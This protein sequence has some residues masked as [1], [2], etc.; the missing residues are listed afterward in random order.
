MIKKLLFA[1]AMTCAYAM[2]QVQTTPAV[3]PHVTFLNNNGLA[4]AGCSLYTYQAGTTTPEPTYTD[5][6]GMSQNPNPIILG[7]DGGANIWLG[8]NSYKL[9]LKDTNGTTVFSVDNVNSSNISACGSATA[10]QI[11]NTGGSGLTCDPTITINT[12]SHTLN[13]GGALPAGHVTIGALGTP[14]SWTFDTTSPATALSSLGGSIIGSGTANQLAFYASNGNNIQGTS[15]I[16]TGITATTQAPNDGSGKIA[17]TFYVAH[18]GAIAPTGVFVNSGTELTDNQGNGAKVQHSTGIVTAGDSAVFDANGNI[19]DAG[20]PAAPTCTGVGSIP[21]SCYQII[22][23]IK[24]ES[25]AVNVP[26]SGTAFNTST[27]TFPL[28][29]ANVPAAGVSTVG[30]P[31]TSGDPTTPAAVEL[32]SSSVTGFTAYMARVIIASAGG[33]NFDQAITLNWWAIGN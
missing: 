5:S 29:F 30:I 23:G 26:S 19:I 2:A 17:N 13:V 24:Y 33:G 31:S 12:A 14:T 21:W 22:G 4:C 3:V 6:S 11:A 16:P 32:Q 9:I 18:P 10:I 25:G 28:A 15:V 20:A 27:V 1:A 7:A 8:T